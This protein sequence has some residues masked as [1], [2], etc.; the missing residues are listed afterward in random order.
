MADEDTGTNSVDT[1]THAGALP[2]PPGEPAPAVTEPDHRALLLR[3]NLSEVRIEA[4]M[5]IGREESRAELGRTREQ[6]TKRTANL[7]E[8]IGHLHQRGWTDVAVVLLSLL[9]GMFLSL[10][11][12]QWTGSPALAA[13]W[14]V[15]SVVIAV[16]LALLMVGETAAVRRARRLQRELDT[17]EVD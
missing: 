2:P 15:V 1:P 11:V 6:L 7:E 17:P 14:L 4:A 8:M 16:I 9:L 10:I 3:M 12:Q 13:A 5:R